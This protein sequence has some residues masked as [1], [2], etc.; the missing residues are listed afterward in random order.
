[1]GYFGS[2]WMTLNEELQGHMSVYAHMSIYFISV[3]LEI[4]NINFEDQ[5]DFS[6]PYLE[7]CGVALF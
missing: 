4:E 5:V 7:G 3:H 1:M 6:T 2:P